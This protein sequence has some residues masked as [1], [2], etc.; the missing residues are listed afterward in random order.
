MLHVDHESFSVGS[1]METESRFVPGTV[2]LE[3]RATSLP[4]LV[5]VFHH[6]TFYVPGEGLAGWASDLS[7]AAPTMTRSSN[8][9][10]TDLKT[11]MSSG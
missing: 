7:N 2:S 5:C 8:A 10:P 11:V 1:G 6:G 3:R 4:G 9:T